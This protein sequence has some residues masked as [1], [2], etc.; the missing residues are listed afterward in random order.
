[1]GNL[2]KNGLPREVWRQKSNTPLRLVLTHD[3]AIT[4]H[5]CRYEP[6]GD[7]P[8]TP[9]VFFYDSPSLL[10]RLVLERA[11]EK[12]STGNHV[13]QR[14]TYAPEDPIQALMVAM[15][16]LTALCPACHDTGYVPMSGGGPRYW[17]TA[18]RACER[19]IQINQA[20][21]IGGL[22]PWE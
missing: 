10:A 2:F 1:M 14:V 7:F 18:C 19:G 12:D 17:G 8:K 3:D 13:W 11:G 9:G 21:K 20:K 16:N 5:D 15:A 4:A 6:S 22:K